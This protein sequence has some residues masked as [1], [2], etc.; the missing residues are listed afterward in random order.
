MRRQEPPP[1]FPA[2]LENPRGWGKCALPR[3]RGSKAPSHPPATLN[4]A[5]VSNVTLQGIRMLV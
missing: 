2:R 1:H 3:A 4:Q 5:T